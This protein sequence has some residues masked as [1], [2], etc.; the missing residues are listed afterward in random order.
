M[1]NETQ[2][3]GVDGVGFHY[4]FSCATFDMAKPGRFNHIGVVIGYQPGSSVVQTAEGNV[5]NRRTAHKSRSLSLI[6]G[7]IRI[8]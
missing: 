4:S 1:R 6:S 8:R 3:R 7:I 2:H 5:D